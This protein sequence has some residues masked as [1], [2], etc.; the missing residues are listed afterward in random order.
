MVVEI[1]VSS[2][3]LRLDEIIPILP[4]LKEK[5]THLYQE[6]YVAVIRIENQIDSFKI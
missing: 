3:N 5:L 2:S 6:N 4:S 1:P